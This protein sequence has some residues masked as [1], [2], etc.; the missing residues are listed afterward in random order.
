MEAHSVI[1]SIIF[2]MI[3]AL[4]LLSALGIIFMH[5]IVYSAVCMIAAFLSAAGIFA[6]LNADFVAVSQVIIYAVGITIVM[7]FAIMLTASR[8][9]KMLRIALKFRT[10]AALFAVSLLFIV[11]ISSVTNNFTQFTEDTG[12]FAIKTPSG[13]VIQK[14]QEEGTTYTIGKSIL[15]DY[16]LPFQVLSMLLLATIIGSVLLAGK[17]SDNLINPTT[18]KIEEINS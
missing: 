1:Y 9:D 5:K 10:L 13:E 6:L 7:I 3:A 12:I 4:L 16:F 18:T 17:T 11:I 14:L 2:Y 15:T 8:I